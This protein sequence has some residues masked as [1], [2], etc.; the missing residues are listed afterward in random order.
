LIERLVFLAPVTG[1]RP[2]TFLAEFALAVALF[3]LVFIKNREMLS[4]KG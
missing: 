1:L 3:A 2:I 4:P